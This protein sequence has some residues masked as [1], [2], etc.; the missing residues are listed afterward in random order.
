MIV[1][2]K[3]PALVIGSRQIKNNFKW[4]IKKRFGK[5]WKILKFQ[6]FETIFFQ[7]FFVKIDPVQLV[8]IQFKEINTFD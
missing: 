2:E 1:Y 7:N 5:F 4:I 8:F 6:K 3:G